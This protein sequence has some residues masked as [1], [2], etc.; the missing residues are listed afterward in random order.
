MQW[1]LELCPGTILYIIYLFT[2][3]YTFL[4]QTLFSSLLPMELYNIEL[5][6]YINLLYNVLRYSSALVQVCPGTALP[7]SSSALVQVCPGTAL[8]WYSFA[9]VQLCPGTV[10]P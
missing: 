8:P 9:L 7:W 6:L 3:I 10:L 4:I 1:T 5:L 2:S